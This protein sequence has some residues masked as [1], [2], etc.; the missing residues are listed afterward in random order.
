MKSGGRDEEK[1]SP[2]ARTKLLQ[3]RGLKT[4]GEKQMRFDLNRIPGKINPWKNPS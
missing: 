1:D 4:Q 3:A 2:Q